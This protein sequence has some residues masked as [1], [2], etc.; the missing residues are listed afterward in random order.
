MGEMFEILCTVYEK[1]LSYL[2]K[3]LRSETARRITKCIMWTNIVMLLTG[4]I[5]LDTRFA[6]VA[7]LILATATVL[8]FMQIMLCALFYRRR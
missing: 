7:G 2:I 4:L 3:G 8:I 5:L 1:V 6:F